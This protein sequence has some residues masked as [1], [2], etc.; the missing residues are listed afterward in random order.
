[1]IGLLAN[2]IAQLNT[3]KSRLSSARATK[4]D[5]LDATISSRAAPSDL[6][7]LDATVSSRASAAD[8]NAT[9][10]AKLDELDAAISTRAA[11]S[12]YTPTRAGYL[13]NLQYQPAAIKSIQRGVITFGSSSATSLTATL[14]P[15]VNPAKTEL[16]FLGFLTNADSADNP[17]VYTP[18]LTLTDGSTVTASRNS[19]SSSEDVSVSWEITEYY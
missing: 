2:A 9:R 17:S 6:S 3:L 11:A 5:N 16:R 13:D 8:Y 14:S 1:M 12:D 7:N 10:A 15:A 19:G 18:M 4:L